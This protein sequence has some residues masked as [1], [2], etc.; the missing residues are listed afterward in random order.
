MLDNLADA[1]QVGVRAREDQQRPE[2]KCTSMH[3]RSS[4]A[5]LRDLSAYSAS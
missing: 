2:K 5:P 1:L 4:P 3:L